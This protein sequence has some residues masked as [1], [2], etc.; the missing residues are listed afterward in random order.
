MT[1]QHQ[2]R[3]KISCL[4]GCMGKQSSTVNH[5]KG[6]SHVTSL[7]IEV[8]LVACKVFVELAKAEGDAI[9]QRDAED[10]EKLQKHVA[11]P[12]T[13][14]IPCDEPQL[15]ACKHFVSFTSHSLP[16]PWLHVRAE[17]SRFRF[18]RGFWRGSSHRNTRRLRC[19][20]KP[21]IRLLMRLSQVSDLISREGK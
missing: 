6:G 14:V 21:Q 3:H 19:L 4:C 17:V 15:C 1:Q 16:D 11:P 20:G 12:T 7:T 18:K 8:A 2:H 5:C 13:C 10:A 9:F